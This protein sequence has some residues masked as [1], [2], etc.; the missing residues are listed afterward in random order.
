MAGLA[1]SRLFNAGG[2][3]G[4]ALTAWALRRSGME[5]RLVACRMVAFLALLY[6]IYAA[7]MLVDGIGLRTGLFPGRH[8]IAITVV[9]AAIGAVLLTVAVAVA[10][11]PQDIERRLEGW[12]RG[13]GP[14]H[15]L[16]A[17]V[18]TGPALVAS[19]LRT[20]WGLARARDPRILGSIG[21]WGCDICVLWASFHAFGSAPPLTVI[22]MAYFVG[23]LGNLLPLP[24]GVGGVDGGMIGAFAA[25]GVNLNL[26]VVAV[27]VYRGI[28]FWLPTLPGAVAYLQLR[29]TVSRWRGEEGDEGP[30][31][32]DRLE[33]SKPAHA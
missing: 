18:A 31:V 30:P 25:F 15:R 4:I 22:W 28:A 8:P 17:R 2:A 29:R 20:A 1:A 16:V 13:S 9:P 32:S 10:L 26:A 5:G 3:G 12:A 27:L 7:S 19:G 24:G 11:L 6:S 23:M 33:A 14:V 21:Y